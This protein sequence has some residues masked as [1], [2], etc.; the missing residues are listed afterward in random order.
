[1]S[2]A[3]LFF[4]TAFGGA[5]VG[6]VLGAYLIKVKRAPVYKVVAWL[7]P[8]CGIAFAGI[9]LVIMLPVRDQL[10][11]EGA[12]GDFSRYLGILGMLGFCTGMV[13]IA[14]GVACGCLG[15]SFDRIRL[16]R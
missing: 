6:S 8:I 13:L 1:M 15:S 5:F 10:T 11:L 7:M 2:A 4:G 9:G 12:T 14:I 16:A 3:H